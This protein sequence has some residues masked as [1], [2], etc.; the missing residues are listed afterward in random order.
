MPCDVSGIAADVSSDI[1]SFNCCSDVTFEEYILFF[2]PTYPQ[3]NKSKEMKTGE[4][5]GQDVSIQ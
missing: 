1:L 4:R 5:G 2:R 3:K